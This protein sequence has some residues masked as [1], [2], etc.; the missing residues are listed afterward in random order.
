[1]SVSDWLTIIG[2]ILAVF[3]IYPSTERTLISLKLNRVE[4]LIILVS[5]LFT[6]YLIKFPEIANTIIFLQIFTV[7]WGF[8]PENLALILFL[9]IISYLAI[10]ILVNIPRCLP[11]TKA[12]DFYV[13]LIKIDFNEF[14]RLFF[15]YERKSENPDNYETYKEIIFNPKFLSEISF[16]IPDYHNK[17]IQKMDDE[18]F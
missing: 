6:L 12:I 18:K 3:A 2:I 10:R 1:M 14:M 17:L 4:L 15:K 9:I 11:N 5:L 7:D 13:E 8:K 16:R